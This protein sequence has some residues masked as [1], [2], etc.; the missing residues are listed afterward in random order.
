ME[1]RENDSEE[2]EEGEIVDDELEDVS[3]YSINSPLIP[4]KSISPTEHLRAVSLSSISDSDLEDGNVRLTYNRHFIPLSNEGVRRYR[5][6]VIHKHR[7]PKSRRKSTQKRTRKRSVSSSDSENEKL[8]RRTLRQLKEAVRI[9]KSREMHIQNSLRTRLKG[10]I[11]PSSAKPQS[12]EE[13]E[14]EQLRTDALASKVADEKQD[15]IEPKQQESNLDD[16]ELTELRLEALK[17]AMLKKHLERKKRKAMG[18]QN[19]ETPKTESAEGDKE[20]AQDNINTE[21]AENEAKKTATEQNVSN[22]TVEEDIDIMRAMLLASMSKKIATMPSL[23]VSTPTLLPTAPV[24]PKLITR[25][26]ANPKPNA[27][28][29]KP[30]PFTRAAKSNYFSNRVVINNVKPSANGKVPHPKMPSV[31]PLI[32]Q[33][34]NDSDSDMDLESPPPEDNITKTVTEFLKKQR[35][36]VEAKTKQ[37]PTDSSPEKSVVKLLPIS[38]QLEYHKL[39]QQLINAKKRPRIRRFS[40]KNTPDAKRENVVNKKTV[41]SKFLVAKFNNGKVVKRVDKNDA[42]SLQRT[43]KDLQVQKDGRYIYVKYICRGVAYHLVRPI[44]FLTTVKS[45]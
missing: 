45:L 19:S 36:E 33:V 22:T 42:S 18:D 9:N 32:I 24:V 10:L 21:S 4:G 25:T 3:D 38:Q 37:K 44:I 35:A 8:D 31:P 2:R 1:I 5:S 41:K 14:I 16:K 17:S 40:Q 7:R 28:V 27:I 23:P 15:E 13:P 34:N 11:E 30:V 43:L 6:L 20:N 29:R 39:K 12:E 26:V